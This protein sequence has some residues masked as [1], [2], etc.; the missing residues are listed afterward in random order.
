MVDFG[1]VSEF[2]YGH[3][4]SEAGAIICL[5]QF[6]V[7]SKALADALADVEAQA[8]AVRVQF[9]F[10]WQLAKWLE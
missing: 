2:S 9:F 5:S 3:P 6:N 7:T 8:I 10:V 1:L 4:E